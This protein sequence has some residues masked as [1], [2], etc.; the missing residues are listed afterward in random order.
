MGKIDFD[1]SIK[2]GEM[3]FKNSDLKKLPEKIKKQ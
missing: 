3:E 1:K 2:I